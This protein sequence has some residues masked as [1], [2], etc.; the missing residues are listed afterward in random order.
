MDRVALP[1]QVQRGKRERQLRAA[2]QRAGLLALRHH[3]VDGCSA[4][5]GQHAAVRHVLNHGELNR[6]AVLGIPGAHR[7]A[8]PHLQQG[9]HR[10]RHR[11]L[12]SL[13][14]GRRWISLRLRLH[15]SI[16]GP[17]LRRWIG[18]LSL[19]RTGA[20][21]GQPL[22]R[23]HWSFVRL[24]VCHLL[25]AGLGGIH[26]GRFLCGLGIAGLQVVMHRGYAG[27]MADDRLRQFAGGLARHRAGK[28]HFALNGRGGDE[29]LLQRL[30]GIQGMHH[31][32][33]DLPV[34]AL[35]GRLNSGCR[36]SLILGNRNRDA[37]HEHPGPR[38]GQGNNFLEQGSI[39]LHVSPLPV[40]PLTVQL[41]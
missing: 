8:G 15:G 40:V 3:S 10:H 4:W 12:G 18:R 28:R 7:L 35:A 31:I 17:G 39:H 30:G 27:Y 16:L 20:P 32:H 29:V 22:G 41:V 9:S 1:A 36:W 37:K 23:R 26:G 11:S 5:N 2:A 6:R 33:L 25:G 21:L 34:G 38:E 13:I 14:G 24:A 19:I